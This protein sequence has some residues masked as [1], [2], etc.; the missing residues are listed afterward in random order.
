MFSV[1]TL[2]S[3]MHIV[4]LALGLGA[5]TVKLIILVRCKADHRLV[6]YFLQIVR[7]I[8]RVIITGLIL[9]SLSGI[10]WI[11]LGTVFNTVLIVKLFFVLVIWLI[12]PYIDNVLEPQYRKLAPVNGA[13]SSQE[14]IQ[15]QNK[16]LRIETVATS[17]FYLITVLGVLI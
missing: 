2:L 7:P 14:F 15:I 10:G 9:V 12:G 1:W 11:I 16:Y 5:A 4:G 8:T 17:L 6:P 3:L 13:Q